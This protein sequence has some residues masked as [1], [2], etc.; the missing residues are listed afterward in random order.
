MNAMLTDDELTQL[1]GAAAES[2]AVPERGPTTVL[3]MRGER[4]TAKPWLRRRGV[5]LTAAA[6]VLVIAAVL[7]QSV[8]SGQGLTK[9]TTAVG[10]AV[11]GSAD[12]TVGG[13]GAGGGTTG[14]GTG[15]TT[16]G[17]TGDLTSAPN[18]FVPDLYQGLAGAPAPAA[19]QLALPPA[20]AT[21]SGAGRAPVPAPHAGPNVGTVSGPLGDTARVVKTGSLSLVV[22]DG[23]VP[24]TVTKVTGL[25]Q[26]A[27]G[28]IS[29]ST[30]E[31][32]GDSPSATLT[33]RVPVGRFDAV[34]GQVR[35]LKA[36]VV[37][38][39]SSGADVTASYADA[40]AQIASLKAARARFLTI[41]AGAKTIGETL[42]VQQRVDDVQA[43]IDRLE[44]QR[45][46]LQ[47]QSDLATLTVTVGEKADVELKTE[48]PSGLSKAWDDAKDG[49]TSGVEALIA[50]SGRALLVLVVGVVAF[51]I[52]RIGWRLARRRLV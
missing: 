36:E 9:D 25:A 48:G 24:T 43:R 27:R 40:E 3:E 52:L 34:I 45:R 28:Y 17:S 32:F 30:S 51:F 4:V 20:A 41:L 49:F 15:G 12:G 2:Y 46:V 37:S 18:E 33:M 42:T 7:S 50:R 26:A 11:P 35:A 10:Q 19:P 5:Q 23:N 38:Q 16:G 6:A 29:E 31:E 14:G 22:D 44:G 39:Q 47:N 21:A 8:G 13:A 1:L